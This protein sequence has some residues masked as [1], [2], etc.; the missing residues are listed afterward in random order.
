MECSATHNKLWRIDY[1]YECDPGE[2]YTI[3]VLA[4]NRD[5]AWN[6]AVQCLTDNRDQDL[7]SITQIHPTYPAQVL[8]IE[9]QPE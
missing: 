3:I 6:M 1:G 5:A 4:P 8:A 7:W 2:V 9:R